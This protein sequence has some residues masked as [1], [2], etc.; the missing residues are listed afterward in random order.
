MA[1]D[2]EFPI[3]T[4]GDFENATER[5]EPTEVNLPEPTDVIPVI[6]HHLHETLLAVE[7]A[8]GKSAA[9]DLVD[10]YR[11]YSMAKPLHGSDLSRTL[12]RVALRLQGYLGLLD[13]PEPDGPDPNQSVRNG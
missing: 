11:G 3:K 13:D 12:E 8:Y 7:R 4:P 6:R 9:E 10:N 2:T 1:T 5:E